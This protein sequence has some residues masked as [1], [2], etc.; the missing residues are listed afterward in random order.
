MAAWTRHRPTRKAERRRRSSSPPSWTL[1]LASLAFVTLSLLLIELAFQLPEP[2]SGLVVDAQLAVWL[3]FVVGFL[4]EL[5]LAP[6]KLRY[7]RKNWLVVLSLALPA[8]RVLRVVRAFRL[9]Q[10]TRAVRA[11]GLA[12]IGASLNRASRVLRDFLEASRFSYLIALT[13]IVIVTGGVAGFFVERGAPQAEINTVGD[14]LWW[15]ATL[16]TTVSSQTEAVSIEG[17]F[18][19]LL[20][21]LYGVGVFGYLVAQLA[22]F[23]FEGK[24][25]RSEESRNLQELARKIEEIHRA[26]VMRAEEAAGG[27]ASSEHEESAQEPGRAR[28]SFRAS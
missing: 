10:S 5:Y 28:R 9:L 1:A 24:P 7:I 12:R 22:A 25:K 2:W 14:G 20:L 23:L 11:V 8:L 15:A 3:A 4:V 16:I 26:V 18:I 17:R 13:L 19:G 6:S 27:P 21:R